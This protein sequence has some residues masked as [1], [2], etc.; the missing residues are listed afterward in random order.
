[1]MKGRQILPAV[2]AVFALA[3]PAC[4]SHRFHHH[5]A[6]PRAIDHSA[7]RSG[8]EEGRIRGEH[9]ARRGR[10]FEYQRHGEYRSARGGYWGYR[11][12]NE[13]HE[14][15]REG[16]VAGYSDGYRRYGRDGRHARGP[17]PY[18]SGRGEYYRSPAA[19]VGYRDGY[20]QGRSDARDGDRF[21]PVRASRYRS[22][23]HEY[24]RRYGSRDEYK[25]I[26][27]SAFQD[28]YQQGYRDAWR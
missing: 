8:Y 13:Y 16:F 14:A 21:D 20:A 15:Y 22:G 27:R 18:G 24:S 7:Y 1:M 3:A 11:H 12:R 10:S 5:P 9:D 6:G 17:H 2:L 25:R 4:A 23:D 19:E 26:Y 28:G